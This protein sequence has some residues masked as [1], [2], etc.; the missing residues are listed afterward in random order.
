MAKKTEQNTEQ[1]KE[2]VNDKPIGQVKEQSTEQAN[3]RAN[4]KPIEQ[5]QF[6][7]QTSESKYEEIA[8]VLFESVSVDVLYFTSDGIAFV[9]L[10]DANNHAVG[11]KDSKVVEVKRK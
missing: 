1:V 5:V 9:Q 6:A 10:S 4:D 7:E 2:Q 11:L 8:K 3:D